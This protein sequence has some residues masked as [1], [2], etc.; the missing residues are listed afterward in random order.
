MIPWTLQTISNCLCFLSF[1]AQYMF[2]YCFSFPLQHHWVT[3]SCISFVLTGSAILSGSKC[4]IFHLETALCKFLATFTVD[5]MISCSSILNFPPCIQMTV[6]P[7]LFSDLFSLS[8]T[9]Y[10]IVGGKK[11][12]MQY[13]KHS[14]IGRYGRTH[15]S[16][17]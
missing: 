9:V 8:S 16:Q 4:H 5:M 11:T 3:D 1:C 6:C 17:S 13:V 10:L 14:F 15:S 7:I 12:C 2:R